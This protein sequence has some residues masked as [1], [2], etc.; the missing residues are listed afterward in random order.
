[1]QYEWLAIVAASL[2]A[3]SSILSITPARHLGTFAYSRWR[4]G[5]VTVILG[6][7]ALVTGG[8]STLG[9][10]DLLPMI[11]S[12]FIGIFIGDTALFSCL[13]RLGPRRAGLLFS[14]HAVFSALLGYWLFAETLTGWRFLGAAMVFSGV[15]IAVFYGSRKD[16]HQ[17]EEV[18]GNIYIA[19]GLGLLAAFCQAVGGVLAKPV[20]VTDVDAIAASAVRMQPPSPLISCCCSPVSGWQRPTSPSTCKCLA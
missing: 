9:S 17:W 12:G 3:L 13:N 8:W 2:W 10:Q 1:M 16:S 18:R 15:M 6:S 20:M 11:L 14:C 19:V 4:M 7:A 5:C